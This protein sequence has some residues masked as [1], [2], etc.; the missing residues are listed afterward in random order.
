MGISFYTKQ[1]LF[2]SK[3]E[4]IEIIIKK[5]ISVF[6]IVHLRYFNFYLQNL[7]EVGHVFQTGQGKN[8]TPQRTCNEHNFLKTF[9]LFWKMKMLRKC[10]YP[11]LVMTLRKRV[12]SLPGI[13]NSLNT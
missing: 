6:Q 9:K 11:F 13:Q 1:V 5:K 4:K 3:V 12:I 8:L 2:L 7:G 10:P